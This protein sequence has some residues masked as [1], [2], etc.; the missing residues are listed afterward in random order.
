MNQLTPID[1]RAE[2]RL[3]QRGPV[4]RAEDLTGGGQTALILLGD[5]VYQLRIT[6]AGKL[7]LT[8]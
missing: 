1:Q 6:K 3:P 5:Q 2:A 4:F 8:K 7:I